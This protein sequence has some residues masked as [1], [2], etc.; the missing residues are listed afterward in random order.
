MISLKQWL[1][2]TPLQNLPKNVGDLGILFMPKALKKILAQNQAKFQSPKTRQIWSH[3]TTTINLPK[4]LTFL[5]NFGE[6]AKIYHFSSE[7]NFG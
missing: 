1:I 2:L 7:I 4:S 6:G 3:C 5:G